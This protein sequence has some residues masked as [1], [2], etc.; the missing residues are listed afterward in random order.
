MKLL[1]LINT[2]STTSLRICITLAVVLGTAVSYLVFG[3]SID[4]SWLGFL[5]VMSGL[6]AAQFT[7]KRKSFI[8]DT[9]S[10]AT[11]DVQEL[12]QNAVG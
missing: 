11:D 7:A 4:T 10:T 3:R 9:G 12:S 6:D 5:V 2:V 1:D 8:P